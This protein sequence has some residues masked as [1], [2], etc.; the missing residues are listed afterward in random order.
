MIFKFF[1]LGIGN[2]GI[3]C[4]LLIDIEVVCFMVKSGFCEVCS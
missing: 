2:I 1:I 4:L 3:F